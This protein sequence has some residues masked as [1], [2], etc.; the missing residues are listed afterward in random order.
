MPSTHEYPYWSSSVVNRF[1]K[2]FLLLLAVMLTVG[3]GPAQA[4]KSVF[5][6]TLTDRAVMAFQEGNYSRVRE[7]LGTD[8]TADDP[9]AWYVL[10]RMYQE[11][12]GGYA[13]DIKRAEKLYRS[14][15]EAGHIDAMLALADMFAR[16]SGVSPNFA[17]ARVWYERAAKA[18]NVPA[19][20]LV[21]N[22]YAGTNGASPD[23]ERARVWYEQAA[24]AGNNAAMMALGNLYRNGQGVELSF[25]EALMWYR[26]AIK[27]GNQDAVTAEALVSRFLTAGELADADQR[28]AEW[29]RLAGWGVTAGSPA[30]APVAPTKP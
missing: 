21:A 14:A 9:R 4:W 30:V 24:A 1:C 17:V 6:R 2:R 20:I 22:D 23:Y 3:T 28:V 7:L 15:A 10:G 11:G 19:M 12:R 25:V 13:L 27:N 5:E 29:E 26:L 18:G 8:E 16:G